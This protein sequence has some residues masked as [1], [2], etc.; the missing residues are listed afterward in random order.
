MYRI[1]VRTSKISKKNTL[2]S[3]ATSRNWRTQNGRCNLSSRSKQNRSHLYCKRSTGSRP[4]RARTSKNLESQRSW[5]SW[6][7]CLRFSRRTQNDRR[8]RWRKRSWMRWKTSRRSLR[9]NP[10]RS[11]DLS[12]KWSRKSASLLLI[13]QSLTRPRSSWTTN[14]KNY[15][16]Y[17]TNSLQNETRK[18]SNSSKALI[19][20]PRRCK[21]R[22]TN[23]QR[24][25]HS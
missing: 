11:I 22:T 20:K 2:N 12:P 6:R 13:K 21:P 25:Y 14:K 9:L 23:C 16:L 4:S 17:Q 5:N 7:K 1:K 19:V 10:T 8:K 24:R 18:L 15:F 3:W